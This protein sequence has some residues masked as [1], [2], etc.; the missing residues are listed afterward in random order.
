MTANE[1]IIRSNEIKWG[2]KFR[3]YFHLYKHSAK[4]HA[5]IAPKPLTVAQVAKAYNYPTTYDGTGQTIGLVELGGGYNVSDLEAF[6]PKLSKRTSWFGVD[7]ATN[8]PNISD[9]DGEV[10]L[11]CEVAGW[12]APGAKI[13]VGFAQNTEQS[14]IN[15][16]NELVARKATT[17][18]ISWGGEE[19]TWTAAGL[20]GI[21]K[22]CEDAA[23]AGIK[24]C[25]A[26][27]DNGFSDGSVDDSARV[28]FPGSSPFVICCGGTALYVNA[29]GSIN[30]EFVWNDLSAGGGSTGG[31]VSQKFKKRSFQ[32]GCEYLKINGVLTPTEWRLVPDVAM[33]AA[34][35]TGYQIWVDGTQEVIGGTSAVSP[36]FAAFLALAQQANG[37][38]IKGGVL[39]LMYAHKN[40]PTE[41]LVFHENIPGSNGLYQSVPHKYDCTS[42][43]GSFDGM[44]LLKR[45]TGKVS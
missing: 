21:N 42:G 24:V 8:S 45:L 30:S 37:G 7:G 41:E 2:G 31:G 26:A 44:A 13:L 27:G 29:D 22:A 38:P 12:M 32:N 19:D 15:V 1:A 20:A 6:L 34:P 3:P 9:A 36:A 33:N 17:I 28:D 14:F 11:D 40:T 16:I 18:S 5:N 23:E 43:L 25:A 39:P 35:S 4:F 10:M